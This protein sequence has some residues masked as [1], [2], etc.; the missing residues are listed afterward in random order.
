MKTKPGSESFEESYKIP[1]SFDFPESENQKQ[2]LS[3][4]FVFKFED[5]QNHIGSD[6]NNFSLGDEDN[7]KA[8]AQDENSDRIREEAAKSEETASESSSSASSSSSSAST[9][10]SAG[11]TSSA[12]TA[13]ASASSTVAAVAATTTT[14]VVLVVGGGIAIYGQTVDKPN[15]CEFNQITVVE[16]RID[17]TLS[18]GNDQLKIDNGEENTECDIKIEL[19]CPSME[20][21][22][23][24]IQVSSFGKVEG[25]FSDLE[26]DTEYLLN[27]S[28]HVMLSSD[29]EYLLNEPISVRT[30]KKAEPEPT[31][32][33]KHYFTIYK[34]L[35]PMGSAT[36]SVDISYDKSIPEYER[37]VVTMAVE[38]EKNG[39]FYAN[40]DEPIE[41]RDWIVYS[42]YDVTTMGRQSI[43]TSEQLDADYYYIA[44]MGMNV[45]TEELHE[46]VA[47][48]VAS[49]D[50]TAE[51]PDLSKN[52]FFIQRVYDSRTYTTSYNAYLNIVGD[53]SSL[54]EFTGILVNPEDATGGA[55]TEFFIEDINKTVPFTLYFGNNS[56][57]IPY[58]VKIQCR[59]RSQ[60]D[61]LIVFDE[62][63]DFGALPTISMTSVPNFTI[64]EVRDPM[65][66]LEF[67]VESHYSGDLSDYS[68]VEFKVKYSEY[69]GDW[70]EVSPFDTTI[71]GKQKIY[72]TGS[73]DDADRYYVALV[74][75]NEYVIV[76]DYVYRYDFIAI[77]ADLSTN[78]IFI[79]KEMDKE[80]G[81]LNFSVY[82]NYIDDSTN[83]V[84]Y[85]LV[86]YHP[87]HSEQVFG[88]F[89]FSDVNKKSTVNLANL[90][91]DTY[92][93]S[94][95]CYDKTQPATSGR[96][97]ITLISKQSITLGYV[98]IRYVTA[99]TIS[100][101]TP[102][103]LATSA[104][105]YVSIN[106]NVF[107]PDAYWD[108]A[109][110][111]AYFVD[112]NNPDDNIYSSPILAFPS[113]ANEAMYMP[114]ID[115]DD[116]VYGTGN[117]YWDMYI[118]VTSSYGYDEPMTGITI[119]RN[120]DEGV[121]SYDMSSI[122]SKPVEGSVSFGFVES[123][124]PDDYNTYLRI[125]LVYEQ[126]DISNYEAF[127]V[128]ITER[129]DDFERTYTLSYSGDNYD[130]YALTE[131]TYDELAGR[132]FSIETHGIYEVS[133]PGGY[134]IF[135]IE[136]DVMFSQA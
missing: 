124:D 27:V 30:E 55:V 125:A 42:E 19:R 38:T 97:E 37:Y 133:N 60:S 12:S 52:A 36:Y 77:D 40:D 3:N 78:K 34:E 61:P 15:I 98:P 58:E 63:I 95:V 86:V 32:V 10:S 33:E 108:Q 107:D 129:Y 4:D 67:Y 130:Y 9:S 82:V 112:P 127:E 85:S 101:G 76:A 20:D 105:K 131:L 91:E 90:G 16:N 6:S 68:G 111:Y 11:A 114:E 106:L 113:M 26:Y 44:L 69:D 119:W 104:H 94:V 17:F 75:Q 126:F 70:M 93:F 35:D 80:T 8:P 79:N 28:Q 31:P 47:E 116:M 22:E 51:Q 136:D 110:L 88:S 23:K 13:A 120:T 56:E 118:T 5:N 49:S 117:Y 72:L 46:I 18:L 123:G 115:Y 66:G 24:D 64:Y 83:Y 81:D 62:I 132:T 29:S 14:A 7:K 2:L 41:E 87:D 92:L 43:F 65:G 71:S 128:V 39:I 53:T 109:T 135:F 74:D 73:L 103:V 89:G 57:Y 54:S 102:Y 134:D 99:P 121:P 59:D 45:E 100:V 50:F 1:E 96:Q 48:T 21:F 84:D 25:Q 122:T